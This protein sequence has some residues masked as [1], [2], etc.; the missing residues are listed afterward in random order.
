MPHTSRHACLSRRTLTAAIAALVLATTPA[1]SQTAASAAA[2]ATSVA[3]TARAADAGDIT[4]ATLDSVLEQQVD[5]AVANDQLGISVSLSGD[6]ALIGANIASPG[7]RFHAG[8]AYVYVREGSAWTLEQRFDGAAANDNFSYAVSLSGNRALVGARL[9]DPGSRSD[10]GSAYFYAFPAPTTDEGGAQATLT[11]SPARPNPTRGAAALTL[12]LPE[13]SAVR[14]AVVDVLGREVAVLAEG[15]Q[16]AGTV[17]VRMPAGRL[18]AGTYVIRATV[19]ERVL[20]QRLTV[21]R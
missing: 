21:V 18:A 8:S 17:A 4:A 10:A 13:A 15:Q 20:I 5:G 12:S 6:R 7:G 14:V 19:G 11:L 1:I 16:A 9:T 2:S 3:E